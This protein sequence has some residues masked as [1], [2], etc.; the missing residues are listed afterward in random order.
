MKTFQFDGVYPRGSAVKCGIT[1]LYG[2]LISKCF[3][4]YGLLSVVSHF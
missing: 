4:F 2:A 3:C 1:L